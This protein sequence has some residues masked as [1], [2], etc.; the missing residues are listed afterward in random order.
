MNWKCPV[1]GFAENLTESLRC[2]CDHEINESEIEH[3]KVPPPEIHIYSSEIK[4]GAASR[5]FHLWIRSL[6]A[7]SFAAIVIIIIFASE[8]V[9]ALTA[10]FSLSVIMILIIIETIV[11]KQI[12]IRYYIV[13]RQEM[14]SMYNTFLFLEI[15]MGLSFFGKFIY[16]AMN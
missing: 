6:Q 15:I 9:L 14:P 2:V 7:I 8:R 3:L 12:S 16:V 11:K 4:Y 13:K 5:K 1:C 10:P